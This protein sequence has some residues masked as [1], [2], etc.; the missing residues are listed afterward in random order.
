LFPLFLFVSHELQKEGALRMYRFLASLMALI[1]FTA[2]ALTSMAQYRVPT[3]ADQQDLGPAPSF[4]G[5]ERQRQ[6]NPYP[7]QPGGGQMPTTMP[8]GAGVGAGAGAGAGM[9]TTMGEAAMVSM[10][11]QVHVL[12]EVKKPGTYRVAASDRVSEILS[13]AGG[14]AENGSERQI[15]LRRRGGG[16]IRVDLVAF[17]LFGKLDQNPYV[18]D[19]DT[20]FVP[21]RKKVIQV[22]GAVKR[23]D[24]YELKDEKTLAD[25]VELSGG[26]N[27]ATAM[28]DP[29]R[30]IRFEEGEKQVDEISI[31]KDAM[32]NYAILNGDVV[33]VPNVVTKNTTFDYNVASVPGDQVFYPSYEDRVFVLGG[34]AVPGAYPFSPYYTLNQ[35]ISLAGGLNERGKSKFSVTTIDGKRHNAHADARVNPGDTIMVKQSWMSPAS[36]MGFALGV[37]SFGL[38]ASATIIAIRK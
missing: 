38:S 22:V 17:K 37:A 36:W 3:Q 11:Y 12:G 7:G 18:T 6:G 33:V 1:L 35:Y 15:E 32:R 9:G 27:A 23:P 34:V 20:V 10:G 25:V 13:R 30:V 31:Q 29:I 4:R 5:S 26:F 28:K 16:V 2:P 19:N 21:L 14:I 8:S 24:F